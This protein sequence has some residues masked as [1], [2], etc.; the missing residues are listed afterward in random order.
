MKFLITIAFMFV[1]TSASAQ[2]VYKEHS[3]NITTDANY[4]EVCDGAIA[5]FAFFE[6]LG[7]TD[8]V[9]INI[10]VKDAVLARIYD[11]ENNEYTDKSF[12]VFGQYNA[13]LNETEI[14]SFDTDYMRSRTAWMT[15]PQ[16]FASG[17]EVTLDVW[18]SVV[19]HE[20]AHQILQQIWATRNP[21]LVENEV[22]IGHG[23]HEY[24]AYS[25]Q[26]SAI[27]D[28]AR[29]EILTTF[30]DAGPFPYKER[31][32]TFMYFVHPHKFGVQSYL[33]QNDDW[34]HDI[35]NGKLVSFDIN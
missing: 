35:V 3:I 29:A 10:E 1:A 9:E 18:Q 34:V 12:Q 22:F 24:V 8:T 28:E 11:S 31:L 23:I 14:S 27:S 33:T 2:C 7:Y 6:N 13:A 21:M 26:L 17:V 30:P 19:T 15:D 16:D 4:N 32:N 25:A 5:A 20:T